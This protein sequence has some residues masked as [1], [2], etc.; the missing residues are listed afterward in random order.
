MTYAAE[1]YAVEISDLALRLILLLFPGI[2]CAYILEVLTVRPTI[3]RFFFVVQVVLCGVMS[4]FL[5]WSM[6]YIIDIICDSNLALN[7]VFHKALLKEKARLSYLEIVHVCAV[8]VVLGLLLTVLS[9]Y[10][11]HLRF[12]RWLRITK[13]TGPL[14]VWDYTFNSPEIRW[15]TVRDQGNDLVYDG[16]VRAFSDESQNAELLLRDVNVCRNS[17]GESL[18]KVGAMYLT[19]A[20]DAIA[21]EF[22]DIPLDEE[23]KSTEKQDNGTE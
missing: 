22:R 13:K 6:L 19:L 20:R 8:A 7:V 14:D 23:L 15:V 16:W 21:I 9:T 10:K 12:L 1:G 4:Y 17:T 5:Y 3:D 18:Y 11:W 2:I